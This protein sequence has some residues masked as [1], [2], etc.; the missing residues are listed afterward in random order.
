M[1]SHKLFYEIVSQDDFIKYFC[2]AM[3][4][5][6]TLLLSWIS[7]FWFK[8]HFINGEMF[9]W[10]RVRYFTNSLVRRFHKT[11]YCLAARLWNQNEKLRFDFPANFKQWVVLLLSYEPF[12]KSFFVNFYFAAISQVRPWETNPDL[13]LSICW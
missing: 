10:Y 4:L 7:K 11:F 2:H 1:L 8:Y 13:Y 9:P 12:H 6:A 3:D 5:N